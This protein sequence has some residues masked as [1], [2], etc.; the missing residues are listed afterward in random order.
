[1]IHACGYSSFLLYPIPGDGV[2][3]QHGRRIV[4]RSR[5]FAF[6]GAELGDDLGVPV[7]GF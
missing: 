2:D 4:V 3:Q 5:D 7:S 1:M 6:V